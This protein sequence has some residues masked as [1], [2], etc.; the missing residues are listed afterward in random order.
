[1]C[2]DQA[3]GAAVWGRIK[4]EAIVNSMDGPKEVFILTDRYVRYIAPGDDKRTRWFYPN[5]ANGNTT[6][7]KTQDVDDSDAEMFYKVRKINGD[8]T[9]RKEAIDLEND[10]IDLGYIIDTITDKGQLDIL[11][12]AILESEEIKGKNAFEIG[13]NAIVQSGEFSDE[14][15]AELKKRI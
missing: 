15:I 4:D 1:M 7:H 11:F 3:D 2:Y 13:V 12:K 10:I 9:L 8:T 14:I 6:L 5:L